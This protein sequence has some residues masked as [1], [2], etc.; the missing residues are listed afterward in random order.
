MEHSTVDSKKPERMK[1]LNLFI[2]F[3]NSQFNS[4]S[5]IEFLTQKFN[6]K[7]QACKIIQAQNNTPNSL[8]YIVLLNI[9]EG[10]LKKVLIFIDQLKKYP[11][12]IALE[13]TG[14][15]T[16]PDIDAVA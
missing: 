3:D 2:E 8:Q 6:W 5:I 15:A 14:S 7:D 4:D 9:R 10:A 13:T 1:T 16:L 11:G 12:V